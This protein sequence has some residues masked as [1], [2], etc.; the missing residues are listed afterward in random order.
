MRR[1][2]PLVV[3]VLV[4]LVCAR[5]GLWQLDRLA[6]R[7]AL[8]T[9]LERQGALAP[10]LL[11][12]EIRAPVAPADLRYRQASANGVF[13]FDRQ[14]VEM[15]RPRQGA[16]GVYVLTPLRLGDGRRVLVNRGWIYSPDARTVD[17]SALME[18]ETTTVRGLFVPPRSDPRAVRPDTLSPDFLPAILRRTARPAGAPEGL[19]PLDPPE[20]TEGP[21]LSYAVQ[22]FA[23]GTIALVGGVLLYRRETAGK[24]GGSVSG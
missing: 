23:F 17:L 6:A 1:Y 10:L 18:P 24:D 21:H 2:V 19:I 16:P 5:L 15:A 12:Q 20:L 8:N 7:R 3:G 22:W 14:V 9:E 11:Q 13:D 4:A